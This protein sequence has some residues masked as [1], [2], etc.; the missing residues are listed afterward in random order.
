MIETRRRLAK[1]YAALGLM[2]HPYVVEFGLQKKAV[3]SLPVY[4][5]EK[6]KVKK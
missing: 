2:D 5:P 1:H 3:E 6:K 4:V